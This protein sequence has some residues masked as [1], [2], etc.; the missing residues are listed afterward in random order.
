MAE[1]KRH[2]TNYLSVR[3]MFNQFLEGRLNQ[4]NIQ[5][6]VKGQKIHNDIVAMLKRNLEAAE[7]G[8]L[9]ERESIKGSYV[10][11]SAAIGKREQQVA[12]KDKK[13]KSLQDEIERR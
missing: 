5:G 2:F 10:K 7:Q 3:N 13:I 8:L 9:C 11:L 1:A 6:G 12:K 4:Q